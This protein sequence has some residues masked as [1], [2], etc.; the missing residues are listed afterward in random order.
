MLEKLELNTYSPFALVYKVDNIN[1]MICLSYALVS[2]LATI[3][4]A[5]RLALVVHHM[6]KNT[7]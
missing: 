6:T 4:C 5:K 2:L 3:N 1:K 7:Y